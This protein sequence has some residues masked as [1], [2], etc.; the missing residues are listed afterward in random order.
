[1]FLAMLAILLFVLSLYIKEKDK[2]RD[3][4][5]NDLMKKLDEIGLSTR[6]KEI[7]EKV[8]EG[9]SSKEIADKLFI[10]KSTVDTHRKNINVKFKKA[11]IKKQFIINLD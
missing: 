9:K 1:M 11:K 6:E 10:E 3:N 8:M 5:H 4:E 7:Q 2:R